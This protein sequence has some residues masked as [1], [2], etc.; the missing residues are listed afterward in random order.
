MTLMKAHKLKTKLKKANGRPPIYPWEQ[1]LNGQV[2]NLFRNKTYTCSD[3]TM[4][5]NI[6]AAAVRL[7]KHVSVQVT[8]DGL[9]ISPRKQPDPSTAKAVP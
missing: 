8:D 5:K 9:R 7:G 3:R 6:R 1:W 2:W 4:T